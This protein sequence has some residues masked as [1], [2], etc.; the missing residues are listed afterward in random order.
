M[1]NDEAFEKLLSKFMHKLCPMLLILLSDPKLL[2]VYEETEQNGNPPARL[3]SKGQLLPFSSLLLIKRKEILADLKLTLP[4]WYSMPVFTAIVAFFK[5]LFQKKKN[6]KNHAAN[7]SEEDIP[8][9]GDIKAAAEELEFSL[10]PPGYTLDSYLD[11]L[12]NRWS[13]LINRKARE[14]LIE[15]VKSLIRDQL[16]RNLKVQKK[17][18]LT[19]EIIGQMAVNIV[20]CNA[21]LTGLSG[22]ESLILYT[23]LYL[24][25]LLENTK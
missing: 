20:T 16:R 5:K 25:K 9:D 13:K 23:E 4:F 19:R 8:E 6:P 14:N 22:R 1:E 12:E 7:E 21:S 15:D 24:L 2:L 10:V 11:E 17:F 18:R 3:F